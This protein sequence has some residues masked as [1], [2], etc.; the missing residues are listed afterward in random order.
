MRKVAL[1]DTSVMSDN[2]GDLIIMDGIKKGMES[3]LKSSMV[4]YM[5]THSPLFHSYQFIKKKDLLN[6]Y[7]KSIDLFFACGSN[8]LQKNMLCRKPLWNIRMADSRL[9]KNVVLVG[10]GSDSRAAVENRYTEELYHR[11][12]SKEYIHSTRDERTKKFLESMGFRAIN[13]GCPTMWQL[14][15]NIHD[16]IPQNKAETVV[17]TVTDY[18]KDMEKDTYMIDVLCREYEQVFCWI[19]GWFDMEYIENI[20]VSKK[21]QFINP[22]LE[23]YDEFLEKTNCDYVGTRLHAGIRAMQKRRR[24]LIIGVDNR[25]RDMNSDFNLNYLERESICDLYTVINSSIETN[26]RIKDQGIKQFINQ[27]L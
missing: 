24:A 7:F 5:P 21:I 18:N 1:L 26:V 23:A 22:S 3:I 27:F 8:L 17:F 15:R 4:I 11:V 10:V 20:N 19:Q 6:R 2:L 9:L 12:L 25:A 14:P 13:T 16:L